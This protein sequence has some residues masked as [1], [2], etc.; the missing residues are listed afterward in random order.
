MST[1]QLI[2]SVRHRNVSGCLQVCCVRRTLMNVMHF[3]VSTMQRV[4]MA[5]PAIV[6]SALKVTLEDSVK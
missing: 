1:T 5:L 3:L 6:V 4:L 2:V